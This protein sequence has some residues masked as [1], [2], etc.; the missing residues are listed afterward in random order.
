MRELL[1]RSSFLSLVLQMPEQE[2]L[3]LLLMKSLPADVHGGFANGRSEGSGKD[4]PG[5]CAPID[6][7]KKTIRDKPIHHWLESLQNQGLS[8][9]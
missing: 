1:Q 2:Q 4:Q 3:A 5:T 6:P 7:F 9:N 8:A